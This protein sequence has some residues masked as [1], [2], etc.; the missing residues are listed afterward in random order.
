MW[1]SDLNGVEGRSHSDAWE[2]V[3]GRG[4]N[5]AG[6]TAGGAHGSVV[7]KDSAPWKLSAVRSEG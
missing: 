1:V 7:S 2:M 3:P 6:G 4:R 5:K